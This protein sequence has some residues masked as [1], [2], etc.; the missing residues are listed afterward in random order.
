MFEA[1]IRLDLVHSNCAVSEPC[2]RGE[3]L[4]DGTGVEVVRGFAF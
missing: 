4:E 3:L 1:G 2:D